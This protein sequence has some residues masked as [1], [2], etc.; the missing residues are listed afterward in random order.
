[1]AKW[2]YLVDGQEV[3]PVEPA[4]LKRL[5]ASGRLKPHDKVRREDMSKVFKAKNVT[6]LFVADQTQSDAPPTS[7]APSPRASSSDSHGALDADQTKST[8]TVTKA[9]SSRWKLYAVMIT[10]LLFVA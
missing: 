5:A 6:G 9:I 2:Y 8:A 7:P 10:L 4:E 3:G 1:M